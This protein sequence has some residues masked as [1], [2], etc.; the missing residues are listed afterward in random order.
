MQPLLRFAN[1]IICNNFIESVK[2]AYKFNL[3]VVSLET[4]NELEREILA[5]IHLKHGGA[6]TE[7]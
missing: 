1:S 2:I 3:N 5:E 6:G 4:V 7:K